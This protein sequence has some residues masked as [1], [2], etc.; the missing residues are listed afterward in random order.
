[1]DHSQASILLS[2]SKFEGKALEVIQQ[3]LEGTPKHIKLRKK[4][5][6][7]AY[8]KVTL[9]GPTDGNGGMMLYTSGTTNR[10]VS[11]ASHCDS[12]VH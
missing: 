10:P 12:P 3:G 7:A 1:M 11:D 6:G 2:S 5:G 4:M 8:E 9:D